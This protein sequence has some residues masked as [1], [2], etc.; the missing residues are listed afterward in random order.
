MTMPAPEPSHDS[1]SDDLELMKFRLEQTRYR[2]DILKWIVIAIGAIVS[3][4]VIDYG[5][6]RLE[7]FRV[8]ADN[9]R[10]LLQ[11]YL[12]ATESP[13]PDV[14][15]RKLHILENFADD[16]RMRDW[17]QA[18]LEY[19]DNFAAL[20]ALYRETLKVASQLVDPGRLND[21]ERIAARIRYNQLYWADLPFAGESKAVEN[22][23]IAFR[24]QLNKAESSPGDEGAWE[25]LNAQLLQLSW[26]LRKTTP[27][28]K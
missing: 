7:Q 19:I 5:K 15:K 18:E 10:Q 8:T 2:T 24:D 25:E 17:A 4:A 14:W 28:P 16:D 6:L 13:Q 22:A 20:D 26:A 1:R 23:M 3:F 11:A 9:Q 21:K 12:K 27:K